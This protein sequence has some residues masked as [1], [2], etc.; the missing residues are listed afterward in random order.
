MKIIKIKAKSIFTKTK[1]PGCGFTINQYIGCQHAC[2]YCYAK[3]YTPRNYGE[4]G[5]WVEVKENAPQLVKGKYVKGAVWMSSVSDPYQPVEKKLKLT[6][7]ILE[8]M[9]RRIRLSIQTKS[10]LVLRD[11]D[12]FKKFKDIEV[13]LTINGFRKRIKKLFEPFSSTHEERLNAL[14]T[15]KEN[16][17]KT[18]GFI[19]PI[20]PDLVDVKRVIQESRNFVDFYWF[21]VLNLRK[22]GKEFINI[23][24]TRFPKSYEIMINSK[25]FY[26]FLENLKEIIKSEEIKTAGIVLHHP[27]FETWKTI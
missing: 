3:F 7:R 2:L 8:R 19:S 14:R 26:K 27:K 15:L 22:S 16:K 18:Y 1:L 24:E 11:I 25:K 21:E 23:L 10:D 9:D 5:T 20:I 13:G 12:L 6:K 4:W 17:I